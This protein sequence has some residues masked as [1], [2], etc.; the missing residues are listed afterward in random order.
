MTRKRN[1]KKEHVHSPGSKPLGKYNTIRDDVNNFRFYK[2]K[3]KKKNQWTSSKLDMVKGSARRFWLW[4]FVSARSKY[5][6]AKRSV[7]ERLFNSFCVRA[8]GG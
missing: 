7:F 1:K 8:S 2:V 5:G 3:R 6:A 4:D